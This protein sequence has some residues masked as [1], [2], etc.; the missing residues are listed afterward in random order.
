[1]SVIL[2]CSSK[3]DINKKSNANFTTTFSPV[4][5]S[6]GDVVRMKIGFIEDLSPSENT[7]NIENDTTATI[8]FGYYVNIWDMNNATLMNDT[9]WNQYHTAQ[10]GG[11][12]TPNSSAF[13]KYIC[14]KWNGKPFDYNHDPSNCNPLY[15]T[16]DITIK[17]GKYTGQQIAQ[18]ITDQLS[19]LTLEQQQSNG[20]FNPTKTKPFLFNTGKGGLTEGDTYIHHFWQLK[21]DKTPP[22]MSLDNAF[23]YST[24]LNPL[25]PTD[26]HTT[27]FNDASDYFVGAS[28]IALKFNA[29]NKFEWQ[30]LHSPI[31]NNS[32]GSPQISTSILNLQNATTDLYIPAFIEDSPTK[33]INILGKYITEDVKKSLIVN[34]NLILKYGDGT[35][36]AV[37]QTSALIPIPL[38]NDWNILVNNDI[39]QPAGSHFTI[40]VANVIHNIN[41]HWRSAKSEGGIYIMDMY[42]DGDND[43]W[44]QLGFDKADFATGYNETYQPTIEEFEKAITSSYQGISS[45]RA[46]AGSM[47]IADN[48]PTPLGTT[49]YLV[50]DLDT[51]HGIIA[52]DYSINNNTNGG[53][54]KL[55]FNGSFEP[56]DYEDNT[57]IKHNVLSIIS[58]Q[59]SSQSYITDFSQGSIVYQH[60]S[61]E[62]ILLSTANFRILDGANNEAINLGN[63]TIFLEI[64]RAS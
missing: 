2:E 47:K 24:Y 28:Q 45:L 38:T 41:N 3:D 46:K 50:A 43:F 18:E 35:Q 19:S 22:N 56:C 12:H 26:T 10:T 48:Q 57:D 53:F 8:K 55:E 7:I 15:Q 49:L 44:E 4:N 25:I 13:N 31:Y 40:V 64:F 16:A 42:S 37:I 21:D 17:K 6:K 60:T 5:I 11:L 9:Y 27:L 20:F 51:T 33:F 59:W 30:Y 23:V 58:R 14:W 1:M 36:Q 52:G 32:T 62:P 34:A 61:E 63:N 39:T 29:D 54:F